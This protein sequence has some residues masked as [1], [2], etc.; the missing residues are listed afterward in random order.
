MCLTFNF[1]LLSYFLWGVIQPKQLTFYIMKINNEYSHNGDLVIVTEVIDSENVVVAN[2]DTCQEYE[3][4][5][6]ELKPHNEAVRG[7]WDS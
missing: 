2:E 5:V 6:T 4:S 1:E 3:V 7:L